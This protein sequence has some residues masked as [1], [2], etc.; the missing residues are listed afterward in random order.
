MAALA[1]VF[2][3]LAAAGCGRDEDAGARVWRTKCSAC[4]GPDGS[5][6]TRFAKGRPYAD[7]TDGRWKH[8]PDRASIRRLVADGDPAS[9]MPPFAGRLT[10]AEVDAVVDHVL[11][12][13]AA[14]PGGAGR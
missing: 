13:A 3:A 8:G 14:R 1:V 11:K 12:L 7:L 6:R 2:T 9:P 10:P 5:G 4:H